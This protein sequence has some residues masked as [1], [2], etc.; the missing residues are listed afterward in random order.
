MSNE[1]NSIEEFR[2]FMA[3]NDDAPEAPATPEPES[4]PETAEGA[5]EAAED[6]GEDEPAEDKP[7]THPEPPKS[8]ANERIRDLNDKA[9]AATARADALAAELAALQARQAEIEKAGLTESEIDPN[10]FETMA[11]YIKAVTDAKVSTALKA[12]EKELIS[13]Q[14]DQ[15]IAEIERNIGNSF[16]EKVAEYAVVNPEIQ[17]AVD[18]LTKY[19]QHIPP[20]VR[21]ALLTDEN[22]A[23]VAWEI[24]TS[25]DLLEQVI[26]GNPLQSI[27]AIARISARHDSAPQKAGTPAPFVPTSKKPVVPEVPRSTASQKNTDSMSN[28]EAWNQYKAGKIK[29]PW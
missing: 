9:K 26:R 25:S 3:S 20:D 12:Q 23:A 27:K 10:K 15:K 8:R 17:Q 22:A 6:T 28:K 29:R 1:I 19:A 5:P 21:M 13:R 18:H 24:A 11:E 7:E 2:A 4:K 14:S 16:S